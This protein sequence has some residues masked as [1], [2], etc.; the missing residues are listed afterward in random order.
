MCQVNFYDSE[1]GTEL[2]KFQTSNLKFLP[3]V[4]DSMVFTSIEQSDDADR[5]FDGEV[6]GVRHYVAIGQI[7]DHDQS[8]SVFLKLSK[9]Y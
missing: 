9:W 2:S 4:G 8:V 6:V 5:Q 1:T 3:R 7:G